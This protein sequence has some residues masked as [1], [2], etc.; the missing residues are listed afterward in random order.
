MN[1]S[2]AA[3]ATPSADASSLS[4]IPSR[5][6]FRCS[7]V[8]LRGG[9]LLQGTELQC[10]R[11][12]LDLHKGTL[13]CHLKWPEP[14][15]YAQQPHHSAAAAA[16]CSVAS[17]AAA[18]SHSAASPAAASS[19][20]STNCS[21][22]SPVNSA[23]F[24]AAAASASAAAT[25]AAASTKKRSRV[26]EIAEEEGDGAEEDGDDGEGSDPSTSAAAYV[27]NPV[28]DFSAASGAF[29]SPST[30]TSNPTNPFALAVP[31]PHVT[32]APTM[33][34]QAPVTKR[35]RTDE[36]SSSI[37]G[38][39]SPSPHSPF[40]SPHAGAHAAHFTSPS[41][42]T[43]SGSTLGSRS[44][45][46]I[47]MSQVVGVDFAISLDHPATCTLAL[48]PHSVYTADQIVKPGT[49]AAGANGAGAES[50][51][52]PRTR[53]ARHPSGSVN[54]ADLPL[55]SPARLLVSSYQQAAAKNPRRFTRVDKAIRRYLPPLLFWIWLHSTYSACL[56]LG[57]GCVASF[58]RFWLT[59]FTCFL[60]YLGLLATEFRR[61]QADFI[62]RLHASKSPED[63]VFYIHLVFANREHDAYTSFLSFRRLFVAA[64]PA[65][66]APSAS[67][68][69]ASALIP[70]SLPLPSALL[71]SP[72]RSHV[73]QRYP[74]S[75][76]QHVLPVAP[77]FF[78][79]IW[80]DFVFYLILPPT[81]FAS[82][83]VRSVTHFLLPVLYLGQASVAAFRALSPVAVQG[84][85]L[86]APYVQLE[87]V[88]FVSLLDSFPNPLAFLNWVLPLEWIRNA[89][90]RYLLDVWTPM[91][92]LVWR[93]WSTVTAGLFHLSAPVRWL[94]ALL[95]PVLEVIR[96]EAR[97]LWGLSVIFHPLLTLLVRIQTELVRAWSSVSALF[98]P[99]LSLFG[100]LLPSRLM[101]LFGA[102]KSSA[103]ATASIGSGISA[104]GGLSRWRSMYLSLQEFVGLI[105]K[106]K[107]VVDRARHNI[108]LWTERILH[109]KEARNLAAH[110]S[111]PNLDVP[112]VMKGLERTQSE[113]SAEEQ[114]LLEAAGGDAI[115]TG[116]VVGLGLDTNEDTNGRDD[117][118]ML[119]PRR[120]LTPESHT[121]TAASS[122]GVSSTASTPLL[123]VP[124]D[125]RNH[126]KQQ[127]SQVSSNV[128]ANVSIGYP[129][130]SSVLTP[131]PATAMTELPSPPV[132]NLSPIQ[133]EPPTLVRDTASGLSVSTAS[134][135]ASSTSSPLSSS[136]SVLRSGP[137]P[138]ALFS[139]FELAPDFAH[140]PSQPLVFEA[141]DSGSSKGL[142]DTEAM[143]AALHDVEQ[144]QQQMQQLEER[145]QALP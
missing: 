107:A 78:G 127:S 100:S 13:S 95:S 29:N 64:A 111:N 73:P 112:V 10:Q 40:H 31:S 41:N 116:S 56:F 84:C 134:P 12:Q 60:V 101:A 125:S 59:A 130:A 106:S 25:A 113:L 115:A 14:S 58:I 37:F 75:H 136:F 53:H 98:A 139:G 74:I 80:A 91:A 26:E 82:A 93:A 96:Q 24:A 135:T 15:E 23:S 137:P 145:K 66:S 17:P 123:A 46:S 34:E 67:S 72:P 39:A 92:R 133:A 3:P 47:P 20:S 140:S 144:Q 97:A 83:R 94:N 109:S 77:L 38:T 129:V 142:W 33:P 81:L 122:S 61:N 57:I 124:K 114:A 70:S 43:I 105:S 19:S 5:L 88:W 28:V 87:L 141:P 30:S 2:L 104:S 62:E 54:L 143:K 32:F 51:I 9:P 128:P 85:L 18:A 138:V 7:S 103:S 126:H 110:A 68:S 76:L 132:F 79:S 102:M 63:E 49:A 11:L 69:G 16:S 35:G 1:A 121:K 120:A 108:Q 131:P 42:S 55:L 90:A 117:D 118:L 45:W 44:I 71:W 6:P 22:S 52:S 27:A 4:W 21:F 119:T 86:L 65:F 48:K 36:R 8:I 50:L 99:L 89:I